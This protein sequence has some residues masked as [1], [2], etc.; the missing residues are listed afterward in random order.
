MQLL[1]IINELSKKTEAIWEKQ[2]LSFVYFE[3]L[4]V[5]CYLLEK[6]V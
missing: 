4:D 5:D 2:V 6:K 1:H 3:I